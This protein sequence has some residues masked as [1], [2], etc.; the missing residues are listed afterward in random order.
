M[1]RKAGHSKA[2]AEFAMQNK[3]NVYRLAY[4]YVQ[5][6]EDALD[7]VQDSIQKALAT[8]NLKDSGALKSWFYRIVVNTSLDFL[9]RRK[10]VKVVDD[11]TLQWHS[12]GREDHYKD[13]DLYE[14]LNKLSPDYRTV[15]VLRFLEDLKI[16]EVAEVLDLNVNT[17][18]TRIYRALKILRIQLENI[19]GVNQNG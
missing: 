7:V 8:N 2:I 12:A 9:R 14:A 16:E 11:H 19:E 18:K 1:N 6:S 17:V 10:K 4:S 3:E 5:N 15:I 13:F